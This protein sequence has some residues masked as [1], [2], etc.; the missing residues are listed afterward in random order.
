MATHFPHALSAVHQSPNCLSFNAALRGWAV[1]VPEV[2]TVLRS[3]WTL[4]TDA[5]FGKDQHWDSQLQGEWVFVLFVSTYKLS[6]HFSEG[7]KVG[8]VPRTP[9]ASHSKDFLKQLRLSGSCTCG[10]VA[11]SVLAWVEEG[12]RHL[13]NLIFHF[14]ASSLE[15]IKCPP[16][17]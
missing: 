4:E 12:G 8:D 7:P 1:R 17:P 3:H 6:H 5:G 10:R 2:H 15:T 9:V 13:V 14:L 16:P 11:N